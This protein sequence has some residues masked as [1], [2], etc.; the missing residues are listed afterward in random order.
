MPLFLWD[1]KLKT[2]ITSCD[3]QHQRLIGLINELFDVM[4][5][6]QDKSIIGK[7]LDELVVY[8]MYHF[9]LEEELMAQH[10]FPGLNRHKAEH[11]NLT[12]EVYAYKTRYN[13]GEQLAPVELVSFLKDWVI[14]HIIGMDKN[15]SAFL[16][17][18]GVV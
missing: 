18:K 10:G 13:N 6:K 11:A 7:T 17:S 9:Q 2:N 4:Q 5:Q 1:N 16:R 8:T 15:Y 14:D 3:E 12:K